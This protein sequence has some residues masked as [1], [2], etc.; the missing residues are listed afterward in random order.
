MI[1]KKGLLNGVLTGSTLLE[2]HRVR[3]GAYK[4]LLEELYIYTCIIHPSKERAIGNMGILAKQ[5]TDLW[6]MI[7]TCITLS[8]ENAIIPTV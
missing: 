8:K 4:V 6:L 7:E 5:R 2:L 3:M 1:R